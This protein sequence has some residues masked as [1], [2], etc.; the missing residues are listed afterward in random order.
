MG[1]YTVS[2]YEMTY[3]G[4]EDCAYKNSPIFEFAQTFRSLGFRVLTVL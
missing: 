4:I 2:L 1:I 3:V